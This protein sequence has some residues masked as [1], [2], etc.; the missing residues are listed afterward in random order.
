MT[1][2]VRKAYPVS[3]LPQDLRDGLPADAMVRVTIETE[4]DARPRPL[5]SFSSLIGALPPFHGTPEEAVAA[6][7]ALRDEWDRDEP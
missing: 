6:V 7:R 5:P 3:K 1:T 4:S 2:V